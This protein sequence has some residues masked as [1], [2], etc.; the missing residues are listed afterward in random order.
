MTG[1]LNQN[2]FLECLIIS[3]LQI[4]VKGIVKGFF[5][6]L[7]GKDETVVFIKHTQLIE[8]GVQKPYPNLLPK[9]LTFG[10]AHTYIAHIRECHPP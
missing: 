10:T 8:N 2:P 7:I 1:P 5:N 9:R 4:D 6:G 3:H